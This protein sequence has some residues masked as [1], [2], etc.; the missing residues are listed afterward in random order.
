MADFE[1][2]LFPYRFEKLYL[3]HLGFPYRFER[4]YFAEV[5]W[6]YRFAS[7][8]KIKNIKKNSVSDGIWTR[9]FGSQSVV[10]PLTPLQ[11]IDHLRGPLSTIQKVSADKRVRH[12]AYGV[13]SK[14]CLH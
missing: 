7:Y 10:V 4:I 12:Q 8:M 3:D 6:P 9:S 13:G 1:D 11:L 5:R 14:A 2:F